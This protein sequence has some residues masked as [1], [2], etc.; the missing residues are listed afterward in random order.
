MKPGAVFIPWKFLRRA[1][2]C[3]GLLLLCFFVLAA[4]SQDPPRS[5]TDSD[6]VEAKSAHG[7]IAATVGSGSIGEDELRY[8]AEARKVRPGKDSY[9]VISGMLEELI[10]GEALYQEAIRIGL[11]QDPVIQQNIRQMLGQALLDKEVVQPVLNREIAEEELKTYY[12]E[13]LDEFSR[14]DQVSLADIFITV[15]ENASEGERQSLQEKAENILKEAKT[16]PDI[17]RNFSELIIKYSN[18]HPLYQLGDTGFFDRKGKPAGLDKSLVQA[19]FTLERSGELYGGVVHSPDGF[20]VVMLVAK[21][22]GYE[23]TFSQVQRMLEQ[24]LRKEELAVKRAE[25]IEKLVAGAQPSVSENVVQSIADD[26][27]SALG[28]NRQR[29]K[30]TGE[31]GEKAA[32]QGL[33]PPP[34]PGKQ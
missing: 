3:G 17:R 6:R 7:R 8:Y 11:D 34:F 28:P 27:E 20:H 32:D 26:I 5:K 30:E 10:T 14:P 23:R 1:S 24:R 13:H 15:P 16:S 9:E 18:T 21:K 31:R 19:A 25:F 29:E 33:A 12:Q 4:C 2:A 22:Q